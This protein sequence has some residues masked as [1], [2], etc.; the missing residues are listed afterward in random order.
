MGLFDKFVKDDDDVFRK[1]DKDRN[2]KGSSK[3]KSGKSADADSKKGSALSALSKSE[4]AA[5]AKTKGADSDISIESEIE[6]NP[7]YAAISK[8]YKFAR[9]FTLFLFIAFILL[10]LTAYKDDITTENFRYLI[11]YLDINLTDSSD[12]FA[13]LHYDA[14]NEMDF[15]AY[16]TDFAVLSKSRFTIFDQIGNTAVTQSMSMSAPVVLS[17]SKYILA[18]DRGGNDFFVFNGF[19][20]LYNSTT[21][22]P[23][24]SAAICDAGSIAIVSSN[25]SYLAHIFVYDRNFT[26]RTELQKD[27]Y[28]SSVALSPDGR[29][30]LI[31][32]ISAKGYSE[33]DSEVMVYDTKE[34]ET[35]YSKTEENRVPL[36]ASFTDNG[37]QIVFTDGIRFLSAEYE[38]KADYEYALEKV[39]HFALCY[40]GCALVYAED[41]I[42]Y[43]NRVAIIG[44]DGVEKYAG[45]LLGQVSGIYADGDFCYVIMKDSIVRAGKGAVTAI[46]GTGEVKKI[47]VNSR[48]IVFAC[49]SN[50]ANPVDFDAQSGDANDTLPDDKKG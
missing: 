38:D 27:R 26:L 40:N 23:I 47:V 4:I 24:S 45:E 11:K 44:S 12:E 32:S 21:V 18:Y 19:S 50:K 10:M 25:S 5:L 41:D 8:K 37:A 31:T 22:N 7:Y 42:G 29:Y 15:C 39:S 36:G 6:E 20:Q 3:D 43:K 48:S 9:Y 1:Y 46:E 14:D 16:G 30:L 33:Y 49:K 2:K 17:S 35:V 34:K 28:V 13:S